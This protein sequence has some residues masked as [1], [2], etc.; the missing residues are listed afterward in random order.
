MAVISTNTF[1]PLRR[2][3]GVRLAQGVPVV[4]ADANEQEDIG[5]F[6]LQSFVRW[7]IGD[8]VPVGL[9][10]FRIDGMNLVND[11]FI[12][13]G[14]SS[15]PLDPATLN[16]TGR[17]ENGLHRAGRCLVNGVLVL[18]PADIRFAQQALH[19]AV[20]GSGA[21]AALWGVPQ[22]SMPAPADGHLL[23]YIDTWERL[24]TPNE[25]PSLVYPGLGVESCSRLRRE[26]VV[27]VRDADEAPQ[28]GDTD[29]VDGHGYYALATITRR[30]VSGSILA[31]DVTDLRRTGVTLAESIKTPLFARKG[32][33]IVDSARFKSMLE[34]LRNA[35]FDSLVGGHLPHITASAQDESIF[36][37]GLQRLLAQAQIG[38][39]QVI[40]RSIDNLDALAFLLALYDGQKRFVGLIDTIGNVGS[41]AAVV[42]F[43]ADYRK[44]L[45]GSAPD[46]IRGL[47]P[48]LDDEDLV[49]AVI[50]QQQINAFIGASGD[51]LP[52]GNVNVF[53]TGVT[54]FQPLAA[55]TPYTFTFDVQS[56]V[57]STDPNEQIDIQVTMS[58]ATW[59]VNASAASLVMT[60]N[61]VLP[62]TVTVTPNAAEPQGTLTVKAVVHDNAL[63]QSPQ[64]G[65][66]LQIGVA[67]PAGSN[68]LI[69]ADDPLNVNSE[70]EIPQAVLT[71]VVGRNVTLNLKN[72]SATETRTYEIRHFIKP[73]V[74]PDTG[75]TPVQATPALQTQTVAPAS[76][77]LSVFVSVKATAAAAPVGT[78]GIITATAKVTAVSGA[79]VADGAEATLEV[80]FRVV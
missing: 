41:T 63:I 70:L 46:A 8:G 21:L 48:A 60:T 67:P 79:P 72:D 20:S 14:T 64:P 78:T 61:Q 75:W 54:P 45:D 44:R 1:D 40:T 11:F 47:K 59:V 3:V 43:I 23:A 15:P 57:V 12:R 24:V 68:F 49:G 35:L 37:L 30:A 66:D 32:T 10:S 25:E 29:Y 4:D 17:W 55:G 28:P 76:P 19:A 33:E 31:S 36:M 38:E 52:E 9:D 50:E 74:G 34:G 69:Y 58:A 18:I 53:H 77:P 65:L 26:W 42:Q 13:A 80:K 27:R 5:K 71:L 39:A 7:F 6:E 51:T 2:F 73:D 22:V 16:P 56:L 62:V